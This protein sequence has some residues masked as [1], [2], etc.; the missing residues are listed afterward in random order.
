MLDSYGRP[1]ILR[2]S[3]KR[4]KKI[5][6]EYIASDMIM[7]VKWTLNCLKNS[8]IQILN[9]WKEIYIKIS[10]G[11]SDHNSLNSSDIFKETLLTALTVTERAN[12]GFL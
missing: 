7:S 6:R 8:L 10:T 9:I 1:L 11:T 3:S 4:S 5:M 12:R 2:K